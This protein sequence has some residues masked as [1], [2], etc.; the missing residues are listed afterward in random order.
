MPNKFSASPFLPKTYFYG[1][2]LF[3]ELG[4]PTQS[5]ARTGPGLIFAEF[6]FHHPALTHPDKVIDQ[7]RV[8]ILRPE[9]HHPDFRFRSKG[10][11]EEASLQAWGGYCK[12]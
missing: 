7:N 10:A 1:K 8:A 5:D 3:S 6:D 9:K 4:R 11:I 2:L 12:W